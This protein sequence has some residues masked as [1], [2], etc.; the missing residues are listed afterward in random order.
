[1]AS[2]RGAAQVSSQMRTAAEFPA[3]SMTGGVGHVLLVGQATHFGVDLGEE[4]QLIVFVVLEH[5]R[6]ALGVLG[7]EDDV[8]DPD[9]AA[10]DELAQL[11]CDVTVELVARKA[12]DQI[13]HRTEW[14]CL[15][16][17]FRP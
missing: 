1:M 9:G 14:H 6:V 13:L 16:F 4:E 2:A 10:L 11:G 8:E 3:S 17:P 5:R 12:D 7:H 15:L